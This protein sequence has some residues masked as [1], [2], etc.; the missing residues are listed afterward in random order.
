[1]RDGSKPGPSGG[2][3][4]HVFDK[5]SEADDSSY[6]ELATLKTIL[7][8]PEEV[9][10]RLTD[11]EYKIFYQV[12][13]IDYLRQVT[14]DL[15]GEGVLGTISERHMIRRVPPTHTPQ[16]KSSVR[17]LIRRFNEVSAWVT[18]LVLSQSSEERKAT[19]ACILRVALTCWN[20][21]N[22]NGAME[23][24]AGL[25]SHK[26]KTFWLSIS[27]EPLPTLDFLSAAL[28][29]AEYE[30][31]LGRA[32]AMPECRLIPFF[33][34]FLRELREI[35][36]ATPSLTTHSV[37]VTPTHRR[38]TK[39]DSVKDDRS[40]IKRGTRRESCKRVDQGATT[41]PL[42]DSC[43]RES[44]YTETS[45][46]VYIASFD[47]EGEQFR[48][49]GPEGLMN[50]EKV[51]R[52]QAVMDHIASFH[53][54]RYSLARTTAP[55]F[56]DYLR[57][58]IESCEEPVFVQP[59]Q[60]TAGSDFENEALYELEGGGY[61]PVQPLPHDHGVTM[62]PLAPQ[63]GERM[64]RHVL[65]ILHHG[66]ACVVGETEWG[67]AFAQ[68]RL[69]R[70][71]ALLTWCR[72]AHRPHS[73][74]GE[75]PSE[76]VQQPEISLSY[77]P[78]E[79]I[80]LKYSGNLVHE[81]EAGVVGEEGFIDLQCVKDMRLGG[82]LLEPRDIAELCACA[83]KHGLETCSQR[84]HIISLVYGKTLSDNRTVHFVL[85]PYSFRVWAVGLHFV[86]K[87]LI[88]QTK[89]ADRS[90]AWL[91]NKFTALYYEDG[92][93]CEPLVSDAIR[94]FGGR[95]S[96]CDSSSHSTPVKYA[97]SHTDSIKNTGLKF[98]KNKSTSELKSSP[99]SYSSH[100]SGARSDDDVV[101]GSPRHSSY[102]AASSQHSSCA[103]RHSSLTA[104]TSV[105]SG[106]PNRSSLR[107]LETS[108]RFWENLKHLRT[109]SVGYDTQLDFM[110]FVA[111]FRSFSL[112]MR[113]ELRDVFEQLAVPRMR[114]PLLGAEKS[115]SS[116]ELFRSKNIFRTGLLTRNGS[117]DL[118]PP[119]DKAGRKKAFDILA[120]AALPG[121]SPDVSGRVLSLPTLGK[122]C[123][124]RQ[125]EPKTEQQLKDIIQRH[126]PDPTLRAENC[127]SFEGFVRFLTD[128][129]NYAFVPEQRRAN[130]FSGKSSTIGEDDL[131]KEL[132][133]EMTGPLSQYY[134]ASS[135]NT[136]L[137]GHQ[138]KGES[139]V[140]LYSQVLLTGCRC[141]E[142]DCWDGDDGNPV[143]YHGHTFTTKIP[144]RRVVETIARS[145]FVT[146]PYPLILSIENHC[147]LPQQQV[148]ASTFEAVF[149]D[150][151]V[152]SFLFEVDY[153]DEP[154]LPSPDQL[155][156]KVLIKNKKLLPVQSSPT[157][158]VTGASSAQGYGGV[159]ATAFRS[160]GI[161]QTSSSLPDASNRT[162]S[163]M[164]NQSAGSSLT[165][166]FSDEDYDEDDEID[167]KELHK[168]LN[169]LEE[170]VGRTSLSL[171]QSLRRDGEG[172]TSAALKHATN[173]KRSNQIA[174][175]LSDMVTYVQ[176]IKFR[177][178]NPISP[179]SS[180]KQPTN[181]VKDNSSA[182][183]C[184]SF[185]SSE[186]SDSAGTQLAVNSQ[187]SRARC[188]NAP[189]AHHPCYRCS[190][191]NE[192]IA[193]KICRK[194]PLALI[195]HT[196]TQLVRTYPAGLRIDSS[197]FDP[198]TFW[199]CGVQLV[200]LN[201]QTEDA[202]MAVNAA[203]YESNGCLGY[204]RK[205]RVMWDPNHIAF[206]RFNPMDKE[207]DG[208]HAAHLTLAV[209]SG[210]YVA[211]NVYS[212]YNA[213]VEVEILG[214]PADC[215]KIKTRV[216]RRNALNPIWNETFNFKVNFPEL[217]FVRFEVYDADTNYMLSQRVIPLLC[218]RPGYRHVRLRSPTNQ[219]LNM[220]SLLI[221]SR[222]A[223]EQAGES[224]RVDA[225]PTSPTQRRKIHFLVVHA[226][227]LHEPYS[228]LK[229]THDTTT[230]EAIAQCLSKAGVCR[231]ARGGYVLV[232]EVPSRAPTQRVLAPHERVLR[233]ATQRPAA[234]LLLKR[235]GDDPSSRAWLTSIRS[236]S[237]VDR[238]KDHT[239]PSD[240]ES[241]TQ[242]ET[243]KPPDSFLVCVHN[244]CHE[245]P[246]A[247]MKV[248]LTATAS[249]VVYQA[250]T[251][252]RCHDNPKRFVLVEELE[253]GGR[254]GAGP[255]QRA[256]A[257]D[258]VVYT[259][260]ASWKTLGRFV[261]Q[262]K[263]STA[264]LPKHRACIARIQ[265]GLSMTRGAIA[266]TT[267][268]PLGNII[269]SDTVAEGKTPVQTA[270]SDPT[271]CRRVST[272][273][274]G[275]GI[276]RSKG[277]SERDISSYTHR[278]TGPRDVHSEGESGGSLGTEALAAQMARFKRVS[279]R[280]LRAWR[281]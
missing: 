16:V 207:F 222:C 142:L 26:L 70:S 225:E 237:T 126:E 228:I 242:E 67:G 82:K 78:E 152:T 203:M 135:H 251:K 46:Q 174:R 24:V 211:E 150:Q 36:A 264:P 9:A 32:L 116:P 204:V 198:V 77:N 254:A 1:M 224:C 118:E 278:R 162:S 269:S 170:K 210:Q 261:L 244:V 115:R 258:E 281:S 243:R 187:H 214:V 199:S 259:A 20:I 48:R 177:G 149:G 280:K 272:S 72:T 270:Y 28:L 33:G 100:T 218:L 25:K 143:I 62:F 205:P 139:S 51:Y 179:R 42:R 275:K 56:G 30:R 181:I 267:G 44:R 263:G 10:L 80:P 29:S 159:L 255:Q 108:E 161:R 212:F 148:M 99:K 182:A 186:S 17:T 8:F 197:N 132:S 226:V 27:E 193:K 40:S 190:S 164:S 39:R 213:F 171:Y 188:L 54:H 94:V 153:T 168:I 271:H 166:Y 95:E 173:R 157:I 114:N 256:L 235:V 220:A 47:E 154:R 266:G 12:P 76:N 122:F 155:K 227:V 202:A 257:D 175:E 81:N 180:M 230:N 158:G 137:T 240:E 141:V 71:C 209:I 200:A 90:L 163:I 79:I 59:A 37:A 128:K 112:V 58:A 21:G 231:S 68:L 124:T 91:K 110:D 41:S 35:L 105:F 229:V 107:R 85:P 129:D 7:N 250:L 192:A 145:A 123:E 167:E 238:V 268:F 109:G 125:N 49:V 195:A 189:A 201:Y 15:G 38:D 93:C 2:S 276:G 96:V 127:F 106:S 121:A 31:A 57:T 245:I 134:I 151:L 13:P 279:L 146:S 236:A 69:E 111:L 241:S 52:T 61:C 22:F 65:Q 75:T 66:T 5:E 196:E 144:F 86:I 92:C 178:L 246:Y 262:E 221:F 11:T 247:I 252:A 53:Q 18:D 19:L 50:L 101:Q 172:E 223:E 140:E 184:S 208:I 138:L 119:S 274:L 248:P 117:L 130:N 87:A 3:T 83:K 216:A 160:N 34:A 169:A 97:E 98:K 277:H 113:S 23:I 185:E 217:A 104:A 45:R 156:Y 73:Q 176:A 55:V 14:L 219:P 88:S 194:H 233:A 232:E 6:E 249:Y 4:G 136:Y 234:R 60:T 102:S 103:P 165:E 253:W 84:P 131:P 147:S 63:N 120:A 239:I 133:R 74:H 260:Q 206:R 64:D 273:P 89:L 215:R 191:V 183:A 43:T 265:R